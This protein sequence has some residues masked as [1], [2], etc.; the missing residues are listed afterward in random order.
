MDVCLNAATY[1]EKAILR[2]LLELHA[3]DLSE[4]EPCA[5]GADGL[6]GY[7]Y[8]DHYWTEAGRHA[9]FLRAGGALAGFALVRTLEEGPPPLRSLAEFFVLRA[10]RRRGVGRAA[11]TALF[12]RFPGRW[13]V[14]QMASNPPAAAFWRKVVVE[15]TGGRFEETS[16]GDGRAGF[17]H[18]FATPGVRA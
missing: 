15:Y 8:L 4:F 3:H 16:R 18:V 12:D 9:L 11:A 13:Q 1:S 17:M 7:R 10:H 5:V 14:P 6:F 2:H